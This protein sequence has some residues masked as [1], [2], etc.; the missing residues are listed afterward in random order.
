MM[1]NEALDRRPI[2]MRLARVR[3]FVT[4]FAPPDHFWRIVT[5]TSVVVRIG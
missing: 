4:T 2:T 3:R 1:S 5:Y